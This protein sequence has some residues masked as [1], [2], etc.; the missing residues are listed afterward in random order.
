MAC[1]IDQTKDL[2]KLICWGRGDSNA[3]GFIIQDDSGVAVNITGFT[4]RLT[5]N[6]DKNPAPGTELFSVVGAITDALNGKIGFAP[7][8]V[9]TDQ[10]PG[11][12]FYDVEQTDTGSLI[13]TLIKGKCQIIQDISK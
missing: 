1:I 2:T 4:F 13:S 10:A 11:L 3:L 6:T 12:Y 8:A 5:V 7:S 9:Q